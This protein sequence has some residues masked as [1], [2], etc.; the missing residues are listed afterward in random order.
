M[1]LTDWQ[2][3][4]G[5]EWY[6]TKKCERII[7]EDLRGW[8]ADDE[9]TSSEKSEKNMKGKVH[10]RLAG[11]RDSP[12]PTLLNQRLLRPL[13]QRNKGRVW[14]TGG[15]L[16]RPEL[17]IFSSGPMVRLTVAVNQV[18]RPGH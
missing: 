12:L 11:F 18:L 7:G 3:D 14:C 15:E 6:Q 10:T 8:E 13:H 9:N 2:G 5:G 4:G 1:G 16:P 17:N